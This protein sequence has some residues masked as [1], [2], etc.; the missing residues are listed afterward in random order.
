MLA[1][2]AFFGV[3]PAIIPSILFD[4]SLPIEAIPAQ[5]GTDLQYIRQLAE[6]VG[7][8][9]YIAAGPAPAPAPPTGGHR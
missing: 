9:F 8:V 6:E 7:Y 2:Y 4:I 1:K 5:Q 3:L